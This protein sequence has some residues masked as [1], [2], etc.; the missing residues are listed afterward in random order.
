LTKKDV[1]MRNQQKKK[2]ILGHGSAKKPKRKKRANYNQI[3][4]RGMLNRPITL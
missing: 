4:Q 2:K 3:H 1:L